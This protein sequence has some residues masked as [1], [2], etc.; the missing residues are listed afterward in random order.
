MQVEATAR[1]DDPARL[2]GVATLGVDEHIWRPSRLGTDRAVTSMVDLTRDEHGCLH[3]RLLDVVPGRSGTGY[4]AWLR[5]RTAE[6]VA[7]IEQAALDPFR[8][9]ANAIRDELPDAVAVLDAFHVVRLGTAVVDEVRRRVQ[10]GTVGHRGH[11]R[12]AVQDPRAA[13]PRRRAPHRTPGRPPRRRPG[14]RR[15]RPRGHA[16]LAVPP[17]AALD[18]PRRQPHRRPPGRRDRDRDVPDLPHRRGRPPRPHPASLET[19]GAGLLRHRRRYPTA[20]PRRST[21]SSRRPAASPT[22]SATSPTT[23]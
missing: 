9:Y 1:V 6:F 18:L 15:P 3:A 19:A 12:P 13:A 21:C 22:G 16:G 2:D 23:G 11:T 10:Q 8:G 17:T 14:R 5:E 7:G 20:A 4:A